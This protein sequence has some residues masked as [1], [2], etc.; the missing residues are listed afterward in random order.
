MANILIFSETTSQSVKSVTLEILG[1]LSE[2]GHSLEVASVGKIPSE[3]KEQ[4]AQH[5]A[6]RIYSLTGASLEHYSPEGYTHALKSLI[7]SKKYDYV[8]A[9]ATSLGKD[10]FPRLAASFESGMASEVVHFS[11]DN[12]RFSGTRPLFAGKC[13][14]KVE[15]EGSHPH[16]ITVRPNA[17]GLPESPTPK[18]AGEEE[19]D[20][21][22]GDL[23]AVVK[24]V[25]KGASEK[26][27]LTEAN[28]IVLRRPFPQIRR[29]LQNPQ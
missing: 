16:F 21:D 27:D 6:S 15:I 24:S 26:L 19:I 13:L 9:G 23:R 18:E 7:E 12:D 29:K 1:K 10:F 20:S 28:I 3:G 11:V 17:L 4:L 25:L 5:G 2:G 14:A 22:S 8:F